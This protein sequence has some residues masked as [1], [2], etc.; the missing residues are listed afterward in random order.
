MIGS[1]SAIWRY[2]V[3]S[4][5][6]E[7]LDEATITGSGV[8]GDRGWATRDEVRG[9]IR[10]AKKIAELMLCSA[11]YL[12]EPSEDHPS[13]TAEL[14]LPD[15]T[16]VRTDD[17][18]AHERLSAAL[19]HRVTLW[20]RRPSTDLDHYRRGAPDTEDVIDELR[21]VFG[22]TDDEPLPDF[23]GWPADVV[24]T[25]MEFESPPGT[26]FDAFPLLL[27]SHQ[28][29][30]DLAARAPGSA[31]DVRRFRPNLVLDLPG[32]DL[33][34]ELALAGRTLAIGTAEIDVSAS[35]PRC[36]M[37]TRP[38]GDLPA[39]REVLRTVV[40]D[41]DQDLGVYATVRTPGTVRVGQP[42]SLVDGAITGA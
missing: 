23:G 38:V 39:D 33:R 31:I 15:G 11:R 10:G 18:D 24:A 41:F 25:I 20:P 8:A 22:R 6:G 19:G 36:V 17:P 35:C 1:L 9:G 4:M 37:V 13:P 26:Y 29:L 28:S 34:P 27:L 40:R 21:S 30:A 32:G 42:V 7:R 5:G 16:T 3:K 14:E 2:P 12:G